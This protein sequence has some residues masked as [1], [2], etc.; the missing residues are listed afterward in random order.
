MLSGVKPSLFSLAVHWFLLE[1]ALRLAATAIMYRRGLLPWD[2]VDRLSKWFVGDILDIG[3]EVV[4]ISFREVQDIE[5][6]GLPC[7]VA[8]I[9]MCLVHLLNACGNASGATTHGSP[10]Q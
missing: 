1:L 8:D 7:R 6:V 10:R 2:D 4:R 9:C 3:L 5:T